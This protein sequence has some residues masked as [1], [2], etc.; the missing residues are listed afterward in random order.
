MLLLVIIFSPFKTISVMQFFCTH[1]TY[2]FVFPA[3]KK[4]IYLGIIKRDLCFSSIRD[5]F[6]GSQE[7]QQASAKL[8]TTRPSVVAEFLTILTAVGADQL[9]HTNW[10][11]EFIT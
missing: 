7:V 5:L 2:E 11:A 6:N 1:T 9:N 4:N 10:V 8:S 3:R